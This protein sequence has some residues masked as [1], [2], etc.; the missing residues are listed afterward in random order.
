MWTALQ[1]SSIRVVGSMGFHIPRSFRQ[2]SCLFREERLFPSWGGNQFVA[3]EMFLLPRIFPFKNLVK[4]RLYILEELSIFCGLHWAFLSGTVPPLRK[5]RMM[6]L[7]FPPP[8]GNL[9]AIIYVS[10]YEGFLCGMSTYR[11][12]PVQS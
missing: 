11:V 5:Q 12:K 8:P 4:R 2:N 9:A 1:L 6:T 10:F 7:K 3:A